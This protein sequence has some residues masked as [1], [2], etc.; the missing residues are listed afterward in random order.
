RQKK[1]R[2]M[3]EKEKALTAYHEAGH[4]LVGAMIPESDPIHKV[5]IIPRGRALGATFTLPEND[6]YGRGRK[7]LEAILAK[8]YGGRVAEE[9][10]FNEISTGA[11]SDIQQATDTAR[12]MVCEYGMSDKLGPISY[13]DEEEHMFLGR[14]IARTQK[15]SD[16]TAKLIDAEVRRLVEEALAKARD[17]IGK[18]REKLELIAQA[19]LKYET[20]TGEE[21]A[22]LLRGEKIDEL[23]EAEAAEERARQEKKAGSDAATRP[24]P[25]WKPGSGPLPGPQQA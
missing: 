8:A 9:V 19:L 25:G 13:T 12:K 3:L 20:I 11:A 16:E 4:T 14:E 6:K 21:V 23:K 24:S 15:H 22:M 17:I 7:E 18:N 5:T 1:S 10:I 2:V